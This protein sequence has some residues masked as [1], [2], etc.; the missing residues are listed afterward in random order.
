MTLDGGTVSGR[1]RTDS[2]VPPSLR[3][4]EAGPHPR[5][6]APERL[7]GVI[8]RSRWQRSYVA[9]LRIT[10][11]LVVV[12]AISLAHVVRFGEPL[13]PAGY[14]HFFLL[15]FSLAFALGW[16]CAL[17]VFH[18]RSP[19]LVGTGVEEYRRVV[20][21]SFGTFGAIAI[22]TLLVKADIARGY[23]AVALPVGTVALVLSRWAWQA[24]VARR[25]A[26]GG[27]RTAVMAF[28][29]ED[30]VVDL[31]TEL[32]RHPADGYDV[33]GIGIPNHGPPRGEHLLVGGRQIPIVGGESDML[34]AI[35]SC[36][37]DTV[38]IAG[39]EHF[40]LRGIRRL[41]WDLEPLGV[42]LVVST[43]VMDVA[44]SRLVMRPIAGLPLLHIEKPQYRGAKRFQKQAFDV[45]FA[46]VVLAV[47]MPAM[48][49]A[50]LAIKLTSRGPVFQTAPRMGMDGQPFSM[51]RFRTTMVGDES[52]SDR[53]L[54]EALDPDGPTHLGEDRHA[55]TTV[56]RVLRRFSIDG[57]PM[58]VN[59][60]KREM[61]VVGPRAPLRQEVEAYDVEVLRR[62]LVRP[63]ITGLWQISGRADLSWNES[64]R[65]DLSYIDNWSMTSDVMIVL[66]TTRTVVGRIDGSDHPD[67]ED[68]ADSRVQDFV[69]LHR[70]ICCI[71]DDAAH[72]ELLE[73]LR[74]P[75][76]PYVVSFVN[77][78]A[79]NLVWH[80]PLLSESLLKSELLLRDGIGVQLGLMAFG[81]SGGLNM[82]GTDL[83]PQIAGAYSG[84][85]AALFGTTSPWLDRA[86]EKLEAAGVTVVA[87]H[88]G[89]SPAQTYVDMAVSWRPDLIILA[90]GMPK[91]ELVASR[92][93]DRLT[94]PVLI[95]NGGAILDFLGEKVTRAPRFMQCTGTEWLY[96]LL[97]EP[98]RLARRYVVG[99]PAFFAHIARSRAV[100]R[101]ATTSVAEST[102]LQSGTG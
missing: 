61:S 65:L 70:R 1:G 89:F 7:A 15:A 43:G 85:R 72:A 39:T 24:S 25:R 20:A 29:E 74:R 68:A 92:L 94:H 26:A 84:R 30:A 36:G 35:R 96:R 69:E 19:L 101:E 28:G 97:V 6:P 11:T 54:L 58:F 40:G 27:C 53:E 62:L 38:A 67:G 10:D 14:P 9:K 41:I 18:T 100:L 44:L 63:G 37:A 3:E 34:A 21:A 5:H 2:T 59:V 49:L 80:S 46:T 77:A 64:V 22:V 66:K 32:T 50:A 81:R 83:I 87:S 42:N 51:L 57:L 47:A 48:V 99:I 33:V 76:R 60:L 55:V 13:N 82:N 86:C 102:P 56:G 78:H 93:R 73:A 88:H 95:V 71:D 17:A 45:C 31:V 75:T 52:R 79:A 4:G 8:E 16:L 98:R 91:Q 23:L 12:G 90:M